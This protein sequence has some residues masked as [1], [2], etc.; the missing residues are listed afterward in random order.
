MWSRAAWVLLA[1]FGASSLGSLSGADAQP[2]RNRIGWLDPG[3]AASA[4]PH[5][6]AVVQGLV[7]YVDPRQVTFDGRYAEGRDGRLRDLAG[8]LVALKVDI[9]VAA[10]AQATDAARH[11]TSTIPIVMVAA[12]AVA[13]GLVASLRE[14][15]GN[16]TG[17]AY[18]ASESAARRLQ[19]LKE[20]LPRASVVA[21][22]HNPADPGN[23][24]EWT[25]MQDAARALGLKLRSVAV[26]DPDRLGSAMSAPIGDR[27]D[28]LIVLGDAS[29]AAHLQ[30]AVEIATR[31]RLPAM[32]GYTGG[33]PGGLMA[34]GPNLLAMYRRAGG[35]VGRILTGA[36]PRDLA[37]EQPSRLELFLNLKTAKALA[38]T[39]PPSLLLRADHVRP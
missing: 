17:V 24:A 27:P 18:A 26:G 11:A 9:I 5:R 3:S 10:G 4:A 30:R 39:V 37:V 28:A 21:V 29:N 35:H 15:G 1:V 7:G 33:P 13:A 12:D 2:A 16:V 6:E 20:L 31:H 32:H 25:V 22:L 34:Y 23:A 14:P 38:L 8:E 36:K 19:L